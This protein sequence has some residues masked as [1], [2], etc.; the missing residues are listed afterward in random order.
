MPITSKVVLKLLPLTANDTLDVMADDHTY[1]HFFTCWEL[2][3]MYLK[4]TPVAGLSVN[5]HRQT[6]S[7]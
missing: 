3:E 7:V 4:P 2:S 5:K 1:L 6:T